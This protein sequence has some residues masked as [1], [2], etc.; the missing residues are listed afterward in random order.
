MICITESL[1]KILF[2]FTIIVQQTTQ[3]TITSS[4]KTTSHNQDNE[5]ADST[6]PKAWM[7]PTDFIARKLLSKSTS[8]SSS[9]SSERIFKCKR[10]R[11]CRKKK[12]ANARKCDRKTGKCVECVKDRHCKV[13]QEC[14]D[15]ECQCVTGYTGVNCDIRNYCEPHPCG[16]GVCANWGT[17]PNYKCS[18]PTGYSGDICQNVP[19]YCFPGNPCQNGICNDYPPGPCATLTSFVC[20]CDTQCEIPNN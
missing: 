8:S 5:I 2:I 19:S 20:N 17:A 18:C 14:V 9:S 7:N 1:V 12:N 6:F 11:Q 4:S 13:N 16:C 10:H 15:N 3:S